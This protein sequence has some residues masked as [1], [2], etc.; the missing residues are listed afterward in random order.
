M[1]KVLVVASHSFDRE[2][3]KAQ[4]VGLGLCA[5]DIWLTDDGEEA[6]NLLE[7]GFDI[8]LILVD[9]GFV[10]FGSAMCGGPTLI[11]K[12]RKKFSSDVP[13][14]ILSADPLII[15]RG[16]EAGANGAVDCHKIA[17][18]LGQVWPDIIRLCCSQ[19]RCVLI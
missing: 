13:I 17:E 4:L 16:Q 12:I 5:D 7:A 1:P 15:S 8:N 18:E 3:V 6:M 2:A 19:E 10:R 11:Y 9:G 14:L